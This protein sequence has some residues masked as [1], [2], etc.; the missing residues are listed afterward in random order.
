[1]NS[2]TVTGEMART[3]E[4]METYGGRFVATLAACYRLGTEEQ[5]MLLRQ[6]FPDVFVRFR[7]KGMERLQANEAE[8]LPRERGT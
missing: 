3:L 7:R 1:V 2:K 6:A 4:T 8:S 5:Q